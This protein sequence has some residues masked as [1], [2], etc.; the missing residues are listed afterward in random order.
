[1]RINKTLWLRN[2]VASCLVLAIFTSSSMVA[3]AKTGNTLFAGELIISGH[4][5]NN[6]EPIVSLNGENVSSGRTIFSGSQ[7]VTPEDSSATIK[8]GKLGS[9]TLAPSSTLNLNFNENSIT[10]TLSS[11][12]VQVFNNEGVTVNIERTGNAVKSGQTQT[13]DD[14]DDKGGMLLP[15][16]IFAGIVGGTFVYVTYSGDDADEVNFVS[17]IR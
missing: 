10:G 2:V 17:P 3:L 5:L 9:L 4:T 1:M 6:F 14:D 7:I 8:L 13:D 16:L 15:I 11:G 12:D